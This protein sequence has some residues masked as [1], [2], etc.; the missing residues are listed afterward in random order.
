MNDIGITKT[1][2]TEVLEPIIDNSAAELFQL[3]NLYIEGAFD[4]KNQQTARNL[5]IEKTNNSY[6]TLSKMS[7]DFD[8]NAFLR[9]AIPANILDDHELRQYKIL[10][11]E[12]TVVFLDCKKNGGYSSSFITFMTSR[13]SFKL[14]KEA[15]ETLM[16]QQ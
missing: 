12:M 8:F 10:A 13:E 2:T 7:P 11:D 3:F 1:E 15:Y 6:S 16:G 9:S 5:W 14:P 4:S